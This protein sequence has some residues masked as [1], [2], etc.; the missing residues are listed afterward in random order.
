MA[1]MGPS[2]AGLPAVL[3]GRARD[4]S[5]A[6]SERTGGACPS[7]TLPTVLCQDPAVVEVDGLAVPAAARPIVGGDPGRQ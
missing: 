7:S 6:Y 1:Q 2:Q 3:S 4:R 5:V